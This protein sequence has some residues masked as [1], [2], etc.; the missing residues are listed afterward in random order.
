MEKWRAILCSSLPV[1][2]RAFWSSTFTG[3]GFDFPTAVEHTLLRVASVGCVA[4]PI[5]AMIMGLSGN[6][7]HYDKAWLNWF[8]VAVAALIPL[9]FY[10]LVRIFLFIEVFISL[11]SVPAGLYKSVNWSYYI[12]NI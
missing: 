8:W 1:H 7:H 5:I 10:G 3:M 12:P 2:N 6:I 4:F 11:R 9:T